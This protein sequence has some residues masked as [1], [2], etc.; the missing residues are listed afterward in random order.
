M[1]H[2]HELND[3]IVSIYIV[4]DN[5]VLLANHPKYEMWAPPGGHVEL[6]EDPEAALYR[7]IKEETGLDV[8][9]LST[10]PNIVSPGSRFLLTPNYMD[11]HE[12]NPPH[13]HIA[14]TYF[15]RTKNSHFIK[16]AEHTELRWFSI[17]DIDKPEFNL[18]PAI[19]F[20]VREALKTASHA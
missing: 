7:E 16:S 20:Y 2:I 11:I 12:A 1:P 9:V 3:F 14:L 13:K 4:H 15:G 5:K 10:K 18:S 19:K 8:E 6:D 17:D